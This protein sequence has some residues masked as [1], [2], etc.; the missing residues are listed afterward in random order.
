[1]KMLSLRQ[2]RHPPCRSRSGDLELIRLYSDVPEFRQRLHREVIDETYPRLHE[3]LRPLSQD[4][5]DD[6]IRA[7]NG[8]IQSKHAVVRYME[9]HGRE[10]D[11]AAWLA[12]EYSGSDSKSL[13]VIRAGSQ[14][15][16]SCPGP[17]YSAGSLSLSRR[18]GFIPKRNRTGLT[19]S[20]PSPSGR[21][22]PS[23][24]L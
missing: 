21:R 17:R 15:E 16:L 20:T 12:Q 18:T 24:V 9:Q 6:A 1:M 22:W 14:R 11:T 8:D 7:W 10:K 23:A 2:C 13:F 4:D 3:M 5:I 19:T